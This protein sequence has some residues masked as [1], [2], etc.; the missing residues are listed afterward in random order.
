MNETIE[1]PIEITEG[2]IGAQ[3]A[4]AARYILTAGGAYAMG[5]G[6]IDGELLNLLTGLVTVLAPVVYGVWKT[7]AEKRIL[8]IVGRAA[9]DSVATVTPRIG[10]L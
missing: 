3:I 10:D 5:K 6:W 7:Y 1:Q 9:P 2:S 4:T 8:V